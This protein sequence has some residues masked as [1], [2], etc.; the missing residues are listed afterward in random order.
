MH[1]SRSLLAS[2]IAVQRTLALPNRSFSVSLA[3][4]DAALKKSHDDAVESQ[5][6][7]DKSLSEGHSLNRST[8]AR[9]HQDLHTQEVSNAKHQRDG[10]SGSPS[11]IDA[12]NL[13]HGKS[14][15]SGSPGKDFQPGEKGEQVGGHA[16]SGQPLSPE[17]GMK[18]TSKAPA[19]TDD[20]NAAGL[21]QTIKNVFG[22]G[23]TQGQ[24]TGF[25]TYTRLYNGAK[26]APESAV[27]KGA[28]KSKDDKV[29]GMQSPHL[30][31]HKAGEGDKMPA[32]KNNASLPSKKG[33]ASKQQVR[34]AS[35]K[36]GRPVGTADTAGSPAVN[37]SSGTHGP[38]FKGGDP[39]AKYTHVVGSPEPDSH[40]AGYRYASTTS[41][42]SKPSGTDSR[43]STSTSPYPD[44]GM[45]EGVPKNAA[46]IGS[47][48]QLTR[49]SLKPAD[50]AVAAQEVG[51]AGDDVGGRG[52]RKGPP[53]FVEVEDTLPKP[54]KQ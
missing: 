30:P 2:R 37:P 52:Q 38:S 5:K 45:M 14:G 18:G 26:A 43:S 44:H 33:D 51:Q 53:E 31:H 41:D 27:D 19:G 49:D 40:Q 35:T 39:S 48:N 22:G 42:G 25:H 50:E 1:V 3:R 6:H 21:G 4:P 34:H 47:S 17:E 36:P 32:V 13:A 20:S 46:G 11:E 7:H 10:R 54:I 23:P 9:K 28:R 8:H 12:V 16:A 29:S 24:K 15:G